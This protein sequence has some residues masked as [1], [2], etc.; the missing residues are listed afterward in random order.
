MNVP[1]VCKVFSKVYSGR[2]AQVAR[3]VSTKKT[4]VVR[5]RATRAQ[6]DG[7]LPR[8]GNFHAKCARWGGKKP[9]GNKIATCVPKESTKVKQHKLYASIAWTEH[10]PT[11][12]KWR[13][14]SIV[15]W[16][17]GERI[18]ANV[19]MTV[20]CPVPRRNSVKMSLGTNQ[21]VRASPQL[22]VCLATRAL[23]NLKQGPSSV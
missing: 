15:K 13:V 6:M 18:R 23:I 7:L 8:K 5:R 2:N 22:A 4:T 12:K 16:G 19:P 10:M 14:V 17:N 20:P 21:P 3:K 9:V 1:I 11:K